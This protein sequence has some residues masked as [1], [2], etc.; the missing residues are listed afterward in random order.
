LSPKN[1][2]KQTPLSNLHRARAVRDA[3]PIAGL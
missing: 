3:K 2:R 1:S